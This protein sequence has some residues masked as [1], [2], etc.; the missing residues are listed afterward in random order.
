MPVASPYSKLSYLGL[1]KEATLT[2]GTAVYPNVF[3]EL[4]SES[5]VTN[6]AI[7]PSMT[8]AG[9]REGKL[10]SIKGRIEPVVGDIT[11]LAE[12]NT[13]G[14]FLRATLGADTP[15]TIQ[16]GVYQHVFTPDT[17][18]PT[19]TLDIKVADYDYV[20]RIT[21]AAITKLS[22]KQADNKIECTISIMGMYSFTTAKVTTAAILGATTLYVDQ[23]TCLTTSDTILVKDKDAEDTTLS[24]ETIGAIVSETQLTTSALDAAAEVN[25]YIVIQPNATVTYDLDSE[26]IWSGGATV[27][28]GADINN[29]SSANVEDFSIEINNEFEP[30]WTAAG[31]NVIN[32]YPQVILLKEFNTNGSFKRYVQDSALLDDLKQN[33]AKAIRFRFYSD[34]LVATAAGAAS[35]QFGAG[36]NGVVTVTADTAGEAGNDYNLIKF[37]L[38]TVDAI[39]ASISGNTITLLL[40]TTAATNTA[41]AIAAA[42]A[43]LSGVGAS[44]SGTGASLITISH[45]I[46]TLNLSG[47]YDASEKDQLRI[48]ILQAHFQPF[49]HQIAEGDIVEEDVAFDAYREPTS[50]YGYSM[51]V[52]LRNGITTYN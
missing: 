39:S 17:T 43:A 7:V 25:D 31:V 33:R 6:F 26:M 12:P 20:R 42:I 16:A 44:A 2:P 49:D 48:D 32:R 11:F 34:A 51:Q 14:Y 13:I 15:T 30:R 5:I 3:V 46:V 37:A 8:I 19:Y 10:R 27:A 36:A 47:G 9:S 41:T 50:T 21:G 24:T 28:L 38:N 45:N 35:A 40:A 4:L 23:T 22:L 29:T 1:G 52:V 18:V